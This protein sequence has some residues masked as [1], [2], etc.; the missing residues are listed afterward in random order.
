MSDLPTEPLLLTKLHV[1]RPAHSLVSRARLLE[2]LNAAA[3]RRLTLLSAPPGFGKTTLLGEWASRHSGP[4]GWVSLDEADND[5]V[6]FWSYIVAALEPGCPGLRVATLSLL[7]PALPAPIES[8]L[9][10]LINVLTEAAV[11]RVLALDDYHL[12][13]S[14]AVHRG[15][16]Y[17]V[18]HLPPGVR[19]IIATRADPP[20]PLARM[21]VRGQLLELRATDLRFTLGEAAA[22]LNQ[23]MGL[24][25][26]A[27][28][29]ATLEERTEGWIAGLQLAALSMRGRDD[30]PAFLA[31]FTGGQRYVLDYL[32]TEVL[33]RQPE[34]IQTFLLQTSIL[35]RMTGALCDVV[36]AGCDAIGDGQAVLEHLEA[37]NLFVV[38]LDNER[39]W[40]R[41]HRL[42]A[43]G[44]RS[45][46]NQPGVGSA[47]S[48]DVATLHRRAAAWYEQH[49]LIAEATPHVLAAHDWEWA[50]R[51]VDRTAQQ[52]LLARGEV[53]TL[54]GW[55]DAL[56]EALVI[57]RPRLCLARAW[58]AI[59]HQQVAGAEDWLRRAED[60]TAAADLPLQGEIA[61]VRSM[62]AILRND[63][64][65]A[66]ELARRALEQLPRDDAFLRSLV[67]LDTGVMHHLSGEVARGSQA[68]AEAVR[69]SHLAGNVVVTVL[70]TWFWAEQERLLG[71][72]HE[73]E[74]IYRAALARPAGGALCC[75]WR[76]CC[77]TVWASCCA[78]GTGWTKRHST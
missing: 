62:G 18:D 2:R 38:P 67:V 26:S 60:A 10:A 52:T 56:P 15:L 69:L 57:D 47:S 35:E 66:A 34:P 37:G 70:A 49:N 21:R 75:R 4:V 9:T 63:L 8:F 64:H 28:E 51:L 12:V 45:R 42:F 22:F 74:A 55:L 11:D 72:L 53:E 25:L 29:L 44:L 16:A 19:L 33:Q 71:H 7:R 36:V 1:P 27:T 39:R 17:L 24:H 76:G 78:N 13:Q 73:A 48:C 65:G 41:Y 77:T 6:R 54:R 23:V 31:A 3:E 58:V 43:E 68:C 59:I 5:P 14:E 61:A 20:L 32:V 50:A 30:I 40:Y 46:L